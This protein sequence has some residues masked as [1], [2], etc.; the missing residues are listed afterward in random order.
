[1]APPASSE[2][3]VAPIELFCVLTLAAGMESM[4]FSAVSEVE[5]FSMGV[6]VC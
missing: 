6:F 3:F 2:L 4:L 1:M 5:G